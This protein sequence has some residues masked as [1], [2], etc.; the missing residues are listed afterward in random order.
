MRDPELIRRAK[1]MRR[2]PTPFERK[3]WLEL[4]AGR[5]GGAKFRQQ[6]VIGPFIADFACRLPRKVIVEVDGD[7]HGVSIERD[8]VRTRFLEDKGYR[9]VRFT[10]ADVGRNMEGVLMTI[11]SELG[12]P[13]SLAL[14]PEGERESC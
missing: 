1:A 3:L 9:V 6:Q 7:S 2:E 10:N 5:L 14:S 4:R 11:V 12:L 13:L 8:E